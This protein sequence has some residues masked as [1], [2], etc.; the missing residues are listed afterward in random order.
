MISTMALKSVPAERRDALCG[1]FNLSKARGLE[2][3]PLSH[4]IVRPD[5]SEIYYVDHASTEELK[6]KYEVNDGHDL[7]EL[8][9]ISYVW[10][11]GPLRGA[12]IPDSEV[13]D[14]AL[15]SH[16]IERVP[17]VVSWIDNILDVLGG[18]GLLCLAIPDKRY[19]FDRYRATTTSATLI[20][21]WLRKVTAPTPFQLYDHFS[22]VVKVGADE[23]FAIFDGGDPQTDRHHTDEDALRLTK[24]AHRTGSYEDCHASVF[25]PRSFLEVMRT[26]IALGVLKARIVDFYDTRHK[27]QEFVCVMQRSYG[28]DVE[29][30]D[31]LLAALP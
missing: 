13:F 23:I 9:E 1:L 17:D 14:Y 10:A 3:G 19:T 28:R 24:V 18:S 25:T 31:A 5:E 12:V 29:S 21:N 26:L 2:F 4:P 8:M 7:A 6:R 27:S 30:I 11:G 22:Q 15:A 20:D 16:V